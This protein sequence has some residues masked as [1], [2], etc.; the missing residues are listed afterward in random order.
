[1]DLSIV[2]LCCRSSCLFSGSDWLSTSV[3]YFPFGRRIFFSGSTVN[4]NSHNLGYNNI[5]I[6]SNLTIL[7][8]VLRTI[9]VASPLEPMHTL[10]WSCDLVYSNHQMLESSFHTTFHGPLKKYVL[11][12]SCSITREVYKDDNQLE[13]LVTLSPSTLYGIFQQYEIQSKWGD[14]PVHY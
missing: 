2:P 8:L 10:L 5:C 11:I 13:I 3:V 7:S 14:H 6:E 4:D 12:A 1:M 9:A